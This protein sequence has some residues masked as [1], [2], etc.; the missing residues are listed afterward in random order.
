MPDN[1]ELAFKRLCIDLGRTEVSLTEEV[2][3]YIRSKLDAAAARLVKAG[4]DLNDGEADTLDLWIMYAAY[5]YRRRDSN[6]TMP[7]SLRLALNDA[8][9]AAA[10][11]GSGA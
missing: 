3:D 5:L 6:E 10:T 1:K 4:I 8:K 2:K 9:V 7:M 11:K